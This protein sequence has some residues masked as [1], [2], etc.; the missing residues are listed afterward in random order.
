MKTEQ[1]HRP[2]AR[3]LT[4]PPVNRSL[5]FEVTPYQ[6]VLTVAVSHGFLHLHMVTVFI[7]IAPHAHISTNRSYFV[8]I[9]RKIIN[10]LPR[11]IH[12]AYISSKTSIHKRVNKPLFF[13]PYDTCNTYPLF[14][15]KHRR[16]RLYY[17][18]HR[19]LS[20]FA[21][22]FFLMGHTCGNGIYQD[23]WV[24]PILYLLSVGYW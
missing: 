23:S 13:K 1:N 5:S 2:T 7:L 4:E 14:A 18:R 3:S 8:V 22:L 15:S 10:H 16:C 20:S 17:K 21:Q 19:K 9:N 11:F 24:Q 12:K 6:E